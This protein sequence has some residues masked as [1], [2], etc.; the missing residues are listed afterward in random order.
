MKLRVTDTAI[1]TLLVGDITQQSVDAIVNAANPSLYGGCGVDGAIHSAGG[2]Q[3]LEECRIIRAQKWPDGLPTG[4][5]VATTAGLLKATHVIHTV[6]PIWRGGIENEPELLANAYR[7]SV[8]LA[9]S[10]KLSSIAFPSISTGVYGYPIEHAAR[11]AIETLVQHLHSM[12]YM[13]EVR[14]VLFQHSTLETF[15]AAVEEV[16]TKRGIQIEM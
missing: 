15:T 10:L 2:P 8:H 12:K 7:N 3:I 16:A 11:I 9:E 6:G 13:R 1:I 5:A 14:M 4:E